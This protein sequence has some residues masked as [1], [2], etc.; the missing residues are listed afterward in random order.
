MRKLICMIVAPCF[1]SGCVTEFARYLAG[2]DSKAVVVQTLN[3]YNQEGVGLAPPWDQLGRDWVFRRERLAAIDATLRSFRPDIFLAQQ[4]VAEDESPSDADDLILSAGSLSGYES[5][6]VMTDLRLSSGDYQFFYTALSLPTKLSSSRYGLSTRA[7][8]IAPGILVSASVA[9]IDESPVLLVQVD[10]Q[11]IRATQSPDAFYPALSLYL[12]RIFNAYQLCRNRI[13]VAGYLP[14]T[15]DSEVDQQY[16]DD[17]D[18]IDTSTK[19]CK[20]GVF[21]DSLSA[22]N[23]LKSKLFPTMSPERMDRILVHK[24]TS[25]LSAGLAFQKAFPA[26]PYVIDT[27]GLATLDQSLRFGWSAELLFSNCD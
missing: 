25:I 16:L 27:Y 22:E 23:E 12:S 26:V 18:L 9:E 3:V 10:N 2:K 21:C 7:E 11:D 14:Q 13:V 20:N 8:R 17:L 15:A 19:V 24:D 1:L 4:M 5:E 6:R